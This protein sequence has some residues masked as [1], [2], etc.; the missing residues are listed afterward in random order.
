MKAYGLLLQSHAE[1]PT[2]AG[3]V[4]MLLVDRSNVHCCLAGD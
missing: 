1:A 3:T 4:A 2:N